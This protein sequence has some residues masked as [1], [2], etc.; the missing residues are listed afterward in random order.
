MA[1]FGAV[2]SLVVRNSRTLR[3]YAIYHCKYIDGGDFDCDECGLECG[4]CWDGSLGS[5]DAVM[6]MFAQLLG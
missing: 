6:K 1:G 3:I 5:Q 2:V 4:E